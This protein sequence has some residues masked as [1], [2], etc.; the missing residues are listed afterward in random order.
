M[1]TYILSNQRDDDDSPVTMTLA[2]RPAANAA[3][4]NGMI[5]PI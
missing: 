2:V 1:A 4:R 5:L 3:V